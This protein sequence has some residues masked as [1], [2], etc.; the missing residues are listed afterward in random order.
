MHAL[1]AIAGLLLIL[2]VLVDAF[3]T[4]V[5][6]RRVTRQFRLARLFF[7]T[8]WRGWVRVARWLPGSANQEGSSWR[9][10][11]LGVYGP[12][13]LLLLLGLWATVLVVGFALLQ[14]GLR[15]PLAAPGGNTGLGTVLYLSGVTFFTLGFGDVVPLSPLGRTVAVFEV[16]T[17]FTFL[18]LVIGYLPTIY[19]TF[20][21][22]ET[23]ITLLDARAGSPPSATELFRRAGQPLDSA[24]LDRFL[25]DWE[26][27]SADLLESQLSYPIL[28][29]FRSQHEH[30]SW[31]AALTMI[32]DTCTLLLVGVGDETGRFS[33]RQARLTF[34]MARHAAGD[35]SQILYATPRAPRMDR[36]PPADLA[37]LRDCLQAAG[38]RLREGE[39]AERWLAELRH[40]YEPYVNAL[41]ERLLFTLPPWLPATTPDAWQ[42]TAWEWDPA[43]LPPLDEWE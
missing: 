41:A 11:F 4:I 33:P 20:A 30:L 40:L 6:P 12:L 2:I 10:G 32:L 9:E 13:A 5:L 7:R 26:R 23:N 27:W 39:E 1:A 35:L 43:R 31:L 36:L 37:R 15:A 38:L 17:G 3:E 16:A 18:A 8:S 29:Y 22:R 19:T 25:H 28:S 21:Q 34:A 42:T 14:W 24:R